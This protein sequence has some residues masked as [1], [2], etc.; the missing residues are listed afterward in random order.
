MNAKAFQ[1]RSDELWKEMKAL[2]A[3]CRDAFGAALWGMIERHF[4]TEDRHILTRNQMAALIAQT[5]R[6][7]RE[8]AAELQPYINPR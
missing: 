2:P 5:I 6:E 8:G 4:V 1:A 3:D 7:Q